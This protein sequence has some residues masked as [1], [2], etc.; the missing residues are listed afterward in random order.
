MYT[1]GCPVKQADLKLGDLLASAA[2]VL[3]INL[4]T[5]A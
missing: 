3:G 2:K 1:L 5:L 4:T